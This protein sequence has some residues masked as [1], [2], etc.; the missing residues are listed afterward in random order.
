MLMVISTVLKNKAGKGEQED[1]GAAVGMVGL[2][3]GW[4]R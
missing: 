2:E 3:S 4:G 1:L